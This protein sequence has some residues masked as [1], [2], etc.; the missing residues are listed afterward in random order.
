MEQINNIINFF[1]NI[2]QQQLID[3]AIAIIIVGVFVILSPAISYLIIKMFK[4]K[5]KDRKKITN[6]PFYKP[7][8]ALLICIGVYIGILV[9]NPP[10]EVI[11]I[12]KQVINIVIICIIAK[13]LVN[14]VDPK[15]GIV[16]KLK[17][18]NIPDDNKTKT[19]ANFTSKILKYI[20]YIGAGLLI[21]AVFGINP[22][23]LIAGL[24]VGSAVV[25]LAA[26]EFVS[27]L[28]SGFSIMADKPFLVGDWI[29]VGTDEG[30]VVELTFRCTKIKTSDNS[31]V[32]IQNSVFTT[33]NVINYSRMKQRRYAMDIK[34]P[35]ETNADKVDKIVNRIRFVLDNNKDVIQG[36]QRV[37]FNTIES[38]GINININMY[39]KIINYT[40]YLD[41]R[42]KINEDI[43][44]ILESEKINIAYP[45]QNVYVHNKEENT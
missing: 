2:T 35:L 12:C 43:L 23:S 40:E 11:T 29:S 38:D 1:K 6:N 9:I 7:L 20:I 8:K 26:Q 21:L 10:A 44:K 30:E 36:T 18:N 17:N 33:N 28:I 24:G 15:E 32:T 16:K 13:G 25:A 5:E 37:Y 31:V 45:G 3:I 27:N 42:Q 41:F 39:T 34:L 19:V 22:S 4:F 14:F